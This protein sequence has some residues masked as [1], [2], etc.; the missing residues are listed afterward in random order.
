MPKHI[1]DSPDFDILSDFFSD[2]LNQFRAIWG[3]LEYSNIV[4]YYKIEFTTYRNFIADV[5]YSY[6][7]KNNPFHNLKHGITVMNC[8]Y[9][10]L[11]NEKCAKLFDTIS[12]KAA[13]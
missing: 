1:L 3:M 4:K 10:F 12:A 9:R 13:F 11:E 6:N 2:M 8:C 7:K 5:A